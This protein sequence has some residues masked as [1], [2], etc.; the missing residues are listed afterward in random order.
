GWLV[1]HFEKMLYDNALLISLMTLVWQSTKDPRYAARIRET[2]TWVSREMVTQNGA[3]AA[4]LDADSEGVEGKFYVWSA[5]EIRSILQEDASLFGQAYDVSTSGNWETANILNRLAHADE[6]FDSQLDTQLEPLRARLQA[7]QD[8]RIRP[9]W[10]DK[11]LTDWNGLMIKAIAE[12]G[13]TFNRPDW[14]TLAK[15]AYHAILRDMIQEGRLAHAWR[16][17]SEAPGRAQHKA[18]SD[19]LSNMISAALTL[20]E[21]EADTKYLE[22]ASAWTQELDDH[23]WDK[24]NHGYFF[25]A[26]DAEGLIRRTRTAND[27][28]T[29]AANGTMIS[30]LIRLYAATGEDT[31]RSRAEKILEAFPPM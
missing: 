15:T 5:D 4:S 28:A 9:S 21:I 26:D 3:F 31:Y 8:I 18:M 24:K 27:D 22:N 20:F 14:I 10:D 16:Q 29:P 25:T 13:Q 12:A 1:P 23:Y 6:P 2:I 7:V 11:V 17:T 30:N 19:G